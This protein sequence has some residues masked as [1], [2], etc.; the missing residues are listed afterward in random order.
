M[1]DSNKFLGMDKGNLPV[2]GLLLT[3]LVVVISLFNMQNSTINRLEDKITAMGAEQ[4]E[5]NALL[6]SEL[7]EDIRELSDDLDALEGKL[8]TLNNDL[9]AL[10][11]DLNALKIDTAEIKVRVEE[12]ERRMSPLESVDGR[13][14]ELERE[15]ARLKERVDALPAESE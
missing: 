1:Q 3:I 7:K 8:D 13:L 15:L 5:D 4:R 14:D 11:S 12:I 10:R 9:D 6:R 2:L